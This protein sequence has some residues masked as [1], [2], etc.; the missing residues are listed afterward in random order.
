MAWEVEFT[1]QFEGWW[2]E[3]SEADQDKITAAVNVLAAEGPKLKRPLVGKIEGTTRHHHLK[4]LIPPASSIR[5][6]FAFDSRSSAI[7]LLGGDKR[8]HW[9]G[10]YERSVPAAEDLYDDHLYQLA[11]EGLI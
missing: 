4:E 1:D 6:L 9:T 5:I 10:W 3:L 7:L 8:G 11:R 2:T